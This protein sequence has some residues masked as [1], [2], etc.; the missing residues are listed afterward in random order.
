MVCITPLDLPSSFMPIQMLTGQV[1]RLIDALSQVSVSCQVLLLSRGAARSRMW[2][3]VP[4]LRQSIVP[5][6]TPLVSLFS[7]AGFWLTQMLCRPL[8]LLFIV[9]IVVLST[10]LI[11]MSS[12]NVPSILRSTATSLASISRKEISSCSPS[13]LLTSLLI[14]LPRLTCLV[15]FE[16][17]YPN[18]RWLLPCH[19]EFEG[20]CQYIAQTSLAHWA[21]PNILYLQF[22]PFACTA[23]IPS[24]YKALFCT[25]L[26]IHQYTDYSVFLSHF[27]LLTLSNWGLGGLKCI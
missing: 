1:I 12:T 11:L 3:P 6:P 4:V 14:S 18:S 27:I 26:Y 20:G 19:L 7:L 10:S 24:L 21:Q 13:P 16:I 9:T 25:L 23:H 2:F 15:V 5:L 17:L 22:T 8:P